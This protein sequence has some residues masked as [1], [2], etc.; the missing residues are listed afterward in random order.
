MSGAEEVSI[1]VGID[2]TDMPG[3][4]G[5][6]QLARQI[7]RTVPSGFRVAL[8]LRHQLL[9]DDRVPYTSQN[10]SASLLVR[11]ERGRSPDEL[12]GSLRAAVRDWFVPGSDPGLAVA[13]GVPEAVSDFGEACQR[14]VVRRGAAHEVARACDVHLEELGGTGDGVIGALAAVG[15]LA[16]GN[17][18]RVVHLEGWPWPDPFAGPQPAERIH[19]RG[20]ARIVELA[21]DG[22]VVEGV[23]DVGRHLRPAY[24][25]REV[26]MFVERADT[27]GAPTS[28]ASWRAVK[29]P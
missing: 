25:E 8:V 20:V 22:P 17:D 15:L 6:N 21:S 5:T 19:E 27:P 13:A 10:G 23:I 2:D 9:R 14:H 28:D 3:T 12:L 7:A 29:L 24:R 16:S 18:G 11:A 26:V 1:Y 4:P